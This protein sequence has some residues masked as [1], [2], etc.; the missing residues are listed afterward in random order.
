[1]ERTS[2]L[3][4]RA[5][6]GH[7]E[8]QRQG[9]P[10]RGGPTDD[11]CVHVEHSSLIANPKPW[12]AGRKKGSNL[13]PARPTPAEPARS[14]R[15]R[16]RLGASAATW[17]RGSASDSVPSAGSQAHASPGPGGAAIHRAGAADPQVE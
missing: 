15:K 17:Q 7:Q 4:K 12:K 11:Q 13:A 10:G 3:T 6:E 9:S 8:D 16:S 14:I 1:M 2:I 5:R